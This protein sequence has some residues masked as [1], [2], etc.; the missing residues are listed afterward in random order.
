MPVKEKT[1]VAI[2]AKAVSKC[3][4][5][6]ATYAKCVTSQL[7]SIHHNACHK[8]FLDFKSCVQKCVGKSW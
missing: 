8:E 3:S 4:L 1:T 2:F 5:Q 7:D 6:A